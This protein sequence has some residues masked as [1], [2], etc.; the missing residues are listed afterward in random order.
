MLEKCRGIYEY[1]RMRMEQNKS[2]KQTDDSKKENNVDW[3]D[4]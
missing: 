3:N 4:F 1:H 2:K